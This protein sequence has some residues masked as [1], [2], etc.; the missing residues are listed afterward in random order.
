[1][2]GFTLFVLLLLHAAILDTLVRQD[3]AGRLSTVAKVFVILVM[4]SL[5]EFSSTALMHYGS[6]HYVSLAIARMLTILI[7]LDITIEFMLLHLAVRDYW[8]SATHVSGTSS[9]LTFLVGVAML[10]VPYLIAHDS[11]PFDLVEAE[12]ELIDGVTTELGGMWFSVFFALES[13]GGWMLAKT[14]SDSSTGVWSWI[15]VYAVMLIPLI[16]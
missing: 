14:F 16:F 11:V 6:N 10:V 13:A 2:I 15:T 7:F 1:M 9:V 8:T 4:A 3:I 12:S 5:V